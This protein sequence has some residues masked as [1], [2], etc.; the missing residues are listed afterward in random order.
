MG[1]FKR[2]LDDFKPADRG[3]GKE[4]N[5]VGEFS[6]E[7]HKH[8]DTKEALGKDEYTNTTV[9]VKTEDGGVAL[10]PE[11][12]G[13]KRNLSGRHI[14]LIALGGSIG[15]GLFI[16]SGQNLATGGP[17]SLMLGFIIVAVC[18]ILTMVS[19]GELAAVLPVS[20]SFCTYSVRFLDPS[21]GFAMGWNY[22]LQWL[23][24]FPLEATSVTIV[25]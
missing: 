7:D 24:A 3:I 1:A 11:E 5:Y 17:G 6:S 15:T 25:I 14:Q 22:W 20:G 13:L 4:V 12:T 8:L 9:A 19:L 16:G 21:W 23:A 2:W 18:V 10:I